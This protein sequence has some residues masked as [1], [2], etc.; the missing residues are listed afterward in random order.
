ML[1]EIDKLIRRLEEALEE[2]EL[3]GHSNKELYRRYKIL[4]R[5]RKKLARSY[6]R[7]AGHE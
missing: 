3:R 7:E 4:V 1:L 5:A 6:R 2:N